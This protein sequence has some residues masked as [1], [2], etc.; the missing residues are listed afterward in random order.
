[1]IDIKL[2]PRISEKAYTQADKHNV[3]AFVVPVS[4]NKIEIKKAV[5]A[6]YGVSVTNV[7]T[8]VQD[9]KQARSIRIKQR[10]RYL[11]GR[12]SDMKKAYVTLKDGDQ[13]PVFAE[14]MSEGGEQ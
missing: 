1:M 8:L 10:G 3:Y 13:I 12:R 9:G 7:R 6:V 5:E 4:A 11:S 14:M 2:I